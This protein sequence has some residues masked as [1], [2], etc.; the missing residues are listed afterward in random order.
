VFGDIGLPELLIILAIVLVLFGAGRV[1]R[2]GKELGSAIG[3]FRKGLSDGSQETPS[4][5]SADSE[6]S[7][8]P[9]KSKQK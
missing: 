4:D 2:V 8:N 9:T 1:A 3:A 5:D 6:D 7:P